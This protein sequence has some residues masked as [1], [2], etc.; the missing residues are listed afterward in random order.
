MGVAH[1]SIRPR[2]PIHLFL[3]TL[4]T[5]TSAQSTA[6]A[7]P[8]RLASSISNISAPLS[9][10]FVGFGIEPTN[11]FSFVGDATP[12]S[13]SLQLFS[14]IAEYAGAP[15]HIR[16]G[17]NTQDYMIYDS[18]Y[19][20]YFVA[21]NPNPTQQGAI[22]ADLHTFGPNFFT[23]VDRFPSGTPVTFG[24]NLAYEATD[25]PQKI[26]NSA[27]AAV[28][29]IKNAKLVSFEIGNEP[30][31]FSK[32][33]FRS[34]SYASPQFITDW[35]LRADSVWTNV[36][37]PN[38]LPSAFFE[39]PT[40][41]S[42]IGTTFE[43]SQLVTNGIL[44]GTGGA[45]TFVSAWNQH[46]YFYF[47]GVSTYGL[48]IATLQQL[49][50][51]EDQFVAWAGQ[52][53]QAQNTGL[54]YNLRE[55]ASA[56]PTGVQ[57]I[58]DTF[59]GALWT[60]NFFCYAASLGI[61]SVQ[62]HMTDNSYASPW[63]P[64]TKNGEGPHVRPSYAGFAAM[65]QLI[66]TGNGTLQM[67][68]LALAGLPSSH[69]D[70]VR[71]YSFYNDGTLA[72]VVVINGKLANSTTSASDRVGINLSL[73]LDSVGGQRLWLQTLDAKG[74]EVTS[75]ATWNGL[76]FDENSDGTPRRV[77]ST[78]DVANITNDGRVTFSIRDSQAIVATINNPI[79]GGT[80]AKTVTTNSAKTSGSNIKAASIL[81]MLSTLWAVLHSLT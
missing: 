36:L 28:T 74:A 20:P 38:G 71:A 65:A 14:N 27:R 10:S 76:S 51:T 55:M 43:I 33:G 61:S 52:V 81:C 60:L 16:L 8:P 2:A 15:S 68:Q 39:P 42:T 63:Q 11:L 47:V 23:A 34:A 66:G 57:G 79:A 49:S 67:A 41:A 30:D 69:T 70:Y 7:T 50:K 77:S 75:G 13:F 45:A 37:S 48:T 25:W 19:Q 72:G 56:G 18:T 62:M 40:T 35:Q 29:L 58:T 26:Q 59:A 22:P 5:F 12:N 53:K 24:L 54:Q 21:T 4:A 64:I 9:R 1:D 78:T 17:G 73:T 32:N 6:T 3:L 46:D 80:V 44:G 31:L